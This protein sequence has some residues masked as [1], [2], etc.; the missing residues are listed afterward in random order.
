MAAFF[1]RFFSRLVASGLCA[2]LLGAVFFS[3]APGYANAHT[4]AQAKISG[5]TVL[6]PLKAKK[7][8]Q[9]ADS[10]QLKPLG[11]SAFVI[12]FKNTGSSSWVPS[13]KK[14]LILRSDVSGESYFYHSSWSAKNI[15][16]SKNERVQPGHLTYFRFTLEAPKKEG[17]YQERL[18]LFLGDQL[19]AGSDITIPIAVYKTPS[20]A[21]TPPV[22]QVPNAK[23]IVAAK[24]LIQMDPI[25]SIAAN[26]QADFKVGFKNTGTVPFSDMQKPVTLRSFA[27][28]ESYFYGPTW[29]GKTV[30]MP[31]KE[32]NPG[33]LTF[34]QFTLHAPAKQGKYIERLALFDGNTRL[35]GSEVTLTITVG[36]PASV[37][38]IATVTPIVV[39][40]HPSPNALASSQTPA[41]SQTPLAATPL[42]PAAPPSTFIPQGVIDDVREQEKILRIGLFSTRD[43]ITI[44]ARKDFEIRDTSGTYFGSYVSGSVATV[45]Y[46]FVTR[47]YEVATP[48]GTST[49]AY[50][51]RLFASKTQVAGGSLRAAVD[52]SVTS[53]LSAD[54]APSSTQPQIAVSPEPIAPA[55]ITPS[56]FPDQDIIFEIT[57]Y[58]HRPGWSSSINDNTFRAGLEVRYTGATDKLWV[59]NELTLEQYL[60]GLA[61]TSNN[62]PYEY[63]KAL[64]I[65]ARTYALYHI[66]RSTKYANEQFTI[67]ATDADQVYRGYGA[68]QRLPNVSHAVTETR[69]AIVTHNGDLAITPYYS[70]SDGRTRN[71]EEVWGGGPKPWLVGKPDPCCTGLKMLGHGVGMSARG[72]L[73]M[74]IEGKGYEEI[75]K[76][77]YTGIEIR[78]RY[79]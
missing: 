64:I 2:C 57:S 42:P 27:K 50:P 16:L 6:A 33:E 24:N 10:L 62:S 79:L 73:L 7:I 52:T 44:T 20:I 58:T 13:A 34:A 19:I 56:P 25:F 67:R 77:Y 29:V 36:P 59:I 11:H 41:Q 28:R 23:A 15:V 49:T 76:Y 71:W 1:S 12:G 48:N 46:D 38:Q 21:V 63:Q 14:Q 66:N 18:N 54:P 65:A 53:T 9:T 74:A 30:V 22:I 8:I 70:Q 68:E 26:G 40:P 72:A 61:E 31:L 32:G 43:P 4:V 35:S 55:L 47:M 60:K 39:P 17:E 75:L 5:K 45:T 37:T 69:G 51:V 3:L 78:R